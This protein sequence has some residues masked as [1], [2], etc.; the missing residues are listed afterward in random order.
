M[1]QEKIDKFFQVAIDKTKSSVLTWHRIFGSGELA[2]FDSRFL[3]IM[4]LQRSFVSR[5]GNG[6]ILLLVN[7]H[8]DDITCFLSPSMDLS[9]QRLGEDNEP[10]LLRLYN[11]VYA[12][13]P[14]AESFIDS[15]ISDP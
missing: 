13:F 3:A 10:Q 4:D 8:T 15:F 9:Y 5:Y 6:R 11:V 1:N 2:N 7:K 14:S 12:Q